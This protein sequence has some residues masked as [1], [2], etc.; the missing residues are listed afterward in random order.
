[1]HN[2]SLRRIGFPAT[3][4]VVAACAS[5]PHRIVAHNLT[6]TQWDTVVECVTLGARASGREAVVEDFVVWVPTDINTWRSEDILF[7]WGPRTNF[8]AKSSVRARDARGGRQEPMEGASPA[9]RRLRQ[10]L[11]HQCLQAYPIAAVSS[12]P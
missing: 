10:Q 2:T 1:M 5:A 9:T 8:K 6:P 3:L 4:L 12:T 7:E 11:D